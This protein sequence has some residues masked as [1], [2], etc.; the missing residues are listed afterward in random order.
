V[1]GDA[2]NAS[3]RIKARA[4]LGQILVGDS[5]REVGAADFD[6]EPLGAIPLKGKSMPVPIFELKGSRETR[7]RWVRGVRDPVEAVPAP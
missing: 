1:L 5:T 4:P 3:A 2:V 7:W 6:F